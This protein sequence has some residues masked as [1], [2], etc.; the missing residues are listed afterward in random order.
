MYITKKEA[1]TI[2]KVYNNTVVGHEEIEV[3]VKYLIENVVI[4][5]TGICY[6]SLKKVVG[7]S[8]SFFDNKIIEMNITDSV[9]RAA[10]TAIAAADDFSG[11]TLIEE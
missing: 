7:D 3:D 11:S 1:V 6:A 8:E 9:I 2:D 4:N 5:A 10:Y